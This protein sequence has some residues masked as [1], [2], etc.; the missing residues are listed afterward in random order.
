MYERIKKYYEMGLYTEENLK[1]F[2]KAEYIT[3]EEYNK[4]IG[5]RKR[6]K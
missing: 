6:N 1:V 3:E 4:I 2:L 5:S